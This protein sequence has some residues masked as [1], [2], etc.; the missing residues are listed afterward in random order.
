[1]NDSK[2]RSLVDPPVGPYSTS[3]EIQAWLDELIK[4]PDDP[5]IVSSRE[6]AERW[7]AN[8]KSRE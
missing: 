6:E 8:V 5:D 2:G 1:M 7:L 3:K 4:M